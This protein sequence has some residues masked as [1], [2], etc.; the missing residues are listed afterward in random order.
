MRLITQDGGLLHQTSYGFSSLVCVV[1]LSSATH[2]CIGPLF[3][4]IGSSP[5]PGPGRDILDLSEPLSVRPLSRLDT[6]L[7]VFMLSRLFCRIILMVDPGS[8]L[9]EWGS[10]DSILRDFRFWSGSWYGQPCPDPS[11]R[12][13]WLL[14]IP[15]MSLAV[16]LS[17]VQLFEAITS[18]P[19]ARRAGPL[20]TTRCLPVVRA[21]SLA[22]VLGRFP[23]FTC[24]SVPCTLTFSLSNF[25]TLLTLPALRGVPL[26]HICTMPAS[27][28]V[29]WTTCTALV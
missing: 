23:P 19:L 4:S 14:W 8:R 27:G 10:P 9:Q 11:G 28:C 7:T 6:P 22:G 25:I 18:C 20:L 1:S 2:S 17:Q 5:G 29:R 16:Y 24:Q 15:L 26:V 21:P 12:S 3:N 13:S